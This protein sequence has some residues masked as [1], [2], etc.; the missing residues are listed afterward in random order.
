MNKSELI[1]IT[2]TFERFHLVF[3]GPPVHESVRNGLLE[4]NSIVRAHKFDALWVALVEN[5]SYIY[6][7]LR[8]R[9]KDIYQII[10]TKTRPDPGYID[11]YIYHNYKLERR[12]KI[13]NRKIKQR[14]K[15]MREGE[16]TCSPHPA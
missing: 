7:V 15:E 10:F 2:L 4:K 11:I 1:T 9:F 12:Q 8:N 16:T 3:P 13:K 14:N 6:V 5:M